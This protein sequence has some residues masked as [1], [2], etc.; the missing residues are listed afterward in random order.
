MLYNI[1]HG[2]MPTILQH[3]VQHV[4]LFVRVVEFDTKSS[5]QFS[6]FVLEANSP[7]VTASLILSYNERELIR[8]TCVSKWQ[9][10]NGSISIGVLT[11]VTGSLYSCRGVRRRCCGSVRQRL[12]IIQLWYAVL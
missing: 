11:A 10:H 12:N 9:V 2:Q 3:V 6:H 7:I 8:Q 5:V 1:T 4:C